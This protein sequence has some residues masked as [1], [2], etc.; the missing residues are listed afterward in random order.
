MRIFKCSAP[1]LGSMVGAAAFLLLGG[2]LNAQQ[3]EARITTEINSIERTTLRG[4]HSPLVRPEN[5]VGRVPSATRLDGMSIVFSRT[6]EQDADLQALIASQQDPGSSLYQQWLTPEQFGARFGLADAD[7][8]VVRSWLEQQGFAVDSVARSRNQITFSGTVQQAEQAFG[9]EL[10][11]Y[12]VN[13]ERH[14]SPH[15]DL[16]LPASLASVVQAVMNLS[17]FRPKSHVKQKGPEPA[18]ETHFTSSQSGDRFLTPSDVATIYDIAPAYH[19]GLNGT[20]QAIAIVGQS[21]IVMTD[22]EHFQTASGVF[23]TAKDPTRT[24]VPGSGTA[25][26][27]T[28]DESESD[29]DLE[30][31][32]TIAPGATIYFVYT[33]NKSNYNVWNSLTYAIQNNVAPIIS[34]SYGICESQ[35]GQ[36][37]YNS[38][39][40]T[41]LA[42]AAAQGQT[43]I[44]ATGDAGSADCVG[45]GGTT[46]AQQLGVDFP[47]S[48]QYVTG[49]GGSE[50]PTP[51]VDPTNSASAQYWQAASGTD[52]ISSALKYIPEIVWNDST[53]G[54][55][56]S[57]GGGVSMSTFTARPSWQTGVPGI[58][59]ISGNGRLVP[60]ISLSASPNNAGYLYCSSDST[61]KVTGSCSHGFRD[62][63]NKNLTVAGGTSFGAPIF[64]GMMAIVNQKMGAAQG[65]ANVKLYSLAAKSATYASAFH[66]ITSGNNNCSLAG[67]TICPTTSPAFSSFNA[68]T[69]YDLATG[70]GS[71]DFNNLLTAWSGSTSLAASKT[72]VT[73]ATSSVGPGAN[74]VITITVA[75]NSSS[76][77]STP[78][79]TVSV[80]VD[81]VT[82]NSSLALRAGVATYTFSSTTAGAHAISA[83]YSGDTTYSSSTG[84]ATVTVT[85]SAKNFTLAASNLTVA[86][87]STGSSTVTVTPQ[88]GY[89]GSI[90]WTVSSNASSANVCFSMA[91][92]SVTGTSAVMASLT[93]KTTSSACGTT[94]M[95]SPVGRGE[96][97][98]QT[99]PTLK[100]ATAKLGFFRSMPAVGVFAAL[101]LLAF[102]RR[103]SRGLALAACALLLISAGLM[104]SGC[105]STS[106]G[107]SSTAAKG[108]YTVTIKGTDTTTSSI[109]ATASMTLTIN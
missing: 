53:S 16:T 46:M 28:G 69:G 97:A 50:F 85:A 82:V 42:Q 58:S 62:T 35:L 6:A 89:T 59:A 26:I 81:N 109:T 1:S 29:L 72:T 2:S 54:N 60:D 80:A 38:L 44:A 24:L 34:M 103:R 90:T 23:T 79:G 51:D 5:E 43:V 19:A 55:L 70:L 40:N 31:A 4:S 49:I 104:V 56:S 20:G 14:F 100:N 52:V 108:T 67:T 95:A 21:E 93:V 86:A 88:N 68:G 12:N 3:P 57:G 9:T 71:T 39:N 105:A 65:V 11:Y 92:T 107:S 96:Y 45:T 13:G 91:N 74:D 61:T 75:S 63:N 98:G 73:A 10:H 17:T 7:I 15:T 106:S 99:L 94:A 32:S 101:L 37:S 25:T 87:G 64:A 27:V 102:G 84:S 30:Y 36:S 48:S 83:T 77:T 41:F 18:T 22:I 8:A 76:S 47:A 78:A 33:G 66:D